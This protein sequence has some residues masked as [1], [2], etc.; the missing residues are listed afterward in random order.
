MLRSKDTWTGHGQRRDNMNHNEED[1]KVHDPAGFSA[2]LLGAAGLVGSELLKLLLAEES[3]CQVTAI[4]RRPIQQMDKKLTVLIEEDFNQLADHVAVFRTDAVFCCLGTTIR[5]AGS[6]V[7][8]SRVDLDYPLEA[9][10]LAASAGAGSYHLISSLGA[11]A[12]S[13]VFYSR[14]KG[15]A[16]QGISRSG[17]AHVSLYRPSLL[18]G[19]RSEK[20]FGEGLAAGISRALPF[21]FSGPLRRYR[22]IPA[23]TVA[24]A[25][26]AVELGLA[27]ERVMADTSA[28]AEGGSTPAAPGSKDQLADEP[29]MKTTVYAGEELFRLAGLYEAHRGRNS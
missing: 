12:S 6:Q 23:A 10:R 16:E 4:V 20:R 14:V 27:D 13:R 8:F 21:V 1:A 18:L 24:R 25:M 11:D 26:V 29:A 22:P 28:L 7:A 15:L 2:V 3:C 9:A 5:T 19:E 17:I